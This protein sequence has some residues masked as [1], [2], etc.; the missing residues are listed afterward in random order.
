MSAATIVADIEVVC[1]DGSVIGECPTWVS[2]ESA[3]YW[4]DIKGPALYRLH[5]QTGDRR[6]WKLP[7]D[8]GAFALV[9][10]QAA[11]IVA[12]RTGLFRLD[13]TTGGLDRLMAPPFDPA[14]FRFNEG[15]VD[16]TG[17]FWFGVMFDP[18]DGDTSHPMKGQLHSYSVSQGMRVHDDRAEIHNGMAF[19]PGGRDMIIAHSEDGSISRLRF[20][21]GNGTIGYRRPFARV[22]SELGVPDGAAMD[23]TGHYWCAVYDGGR[24]RRFTPDGQ[25]DRDILLPISKPTMCCFAGKDLDTLYVTSATEHLTPDQRRE[26]PLAGALL[27]LDP[28][29]LGLAKPVYVR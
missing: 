8:C 14:L 17:R 12:L 20:D 15:I 4:V 23:E 6:T 10:G 9:H 22:P 1:R 5:H 19:V 2:A 3:L 11:A 28:G 16:E 29:V 7:S 21:P 18:L 13:L 27:R 24:L 26:Q 25:V